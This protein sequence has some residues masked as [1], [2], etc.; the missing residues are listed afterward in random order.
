MYCN[1]T[2]SKTKAFISACHNGYSRMNSHCF[3]GDSPK[4]LCSWAVLIFGTET[5]YCT[6]N[7]INR[8]PYTLLHPYD[9][10]VSSGYGW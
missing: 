5:W 7:A 4:P 9:K 8:V 6:F 10:S 3:M 2:Y 1:L